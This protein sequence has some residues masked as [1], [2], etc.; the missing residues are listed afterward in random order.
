MGEALARRRLLGEIAVYGG[1]AVM[2]QFDVSFATRDA[3]DALLLA[4]A[5]GRVSLGD[6]MA[7]YRRTFPG[8]EPDARRAVAIADLAARLTREAEGGGDAP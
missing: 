7:L 2:F 4:R 3:D 5:T 1:A 6:L 8:E